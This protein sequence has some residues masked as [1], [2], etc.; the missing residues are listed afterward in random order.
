MKGARRD[1]RYQGDKRYQL[2]V[3][4][5]GLFNSDISQLDDDEVEELL[6]Y[7][8]I[9][10]ADPNLARKSRKAWHVYRSSLVNRLH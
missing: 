2:R 8:D 3:R 5:F 7:C 10:L 6:S 9:V 4:D 1:K